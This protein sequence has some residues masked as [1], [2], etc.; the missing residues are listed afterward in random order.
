MMMRHFAASAAVAVVTG[1]GLAFAQEA[2]PNAEQASEARYVPEWEE[3]P[4]ARSFAQNYPRAAMQRNIGAVVILCCTPQSNRRLECSVGLDSQ[5][6]HNF[7]AAA[8]RISREFKLTSQSHAEYQSDP[9]N[10]LRVPITFAMG[11][12]TPELEAVRASLQGENAGLCRP[13][14]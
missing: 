2:A 5:P 14:T 6:E 11:S 3:R 1:L 8:Q 9:N 12:V 13:Q 4:S 10:W 7:G